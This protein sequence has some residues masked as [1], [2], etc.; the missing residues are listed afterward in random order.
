MVLVGPSGCGKSTALR[1]VAGLDDPSEGRI[2]ISDR[3]VAGVSPAAR[4]VAM[5]FQSYAL[6]PH[7]TVRKNLAF[8]LERRRMPRQRIRERVDEVSGMLGLDEL[9]DRK[10]AQL[11]GGQRQRVAMGRALSR[12][13]EVFLLDEPLSNL[14]AKLRAELRAELKQLHARVGTTMIFV[15]HDQ[16]EAMTLGDRIAVLDKGRLQQV[17]EPNEVYGRPR[18]LFVAGFVGSPAMNMLPG[19][20]LGHPA[21]LVAGVR[22]ESLKP[23]VEVP[24]GLP[25]EL[26]AQVVEPLGSD[27]FVHGT[28]DGVTCVARLPGS[29]LVAPGERLQLAVPPADVH[30]FDVSSGERVERP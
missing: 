11:S 25:L 4:D 1:M 28:A 12:D 15:T 14:D 24:G 30:L 29:A 22:P 19:P 7:M 8:P 27:V 9:L 6:Y 10:P 21:G 3:D 2:M 20:A 13:P 5:V 16:V 18:N 23:D 26:V 17:G